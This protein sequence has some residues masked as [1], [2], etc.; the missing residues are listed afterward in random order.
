M[1][2]YFLG[3][4]PPLHPSSEFERKRWLSE[5]KTKQQSP[6]RSVGYI[7]MWNRR[8]VGYGIFRPFWNRLV[9]KKLHAKIGIC[10]NWWILSSWKCFHVFNDLFSD[11]LV[12]LLAIDSCLIQYQVAHLE[13][14]TRIPQSFRKSPFPT[15]SVGLWEDV[16]DFPVGVNYDDLLTY[17]LDI[18]KPPS[19]S[20][21]QLFS[22]YA[23]VIDP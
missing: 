9:A 3:R 1:K 19:Q 14:W 18:M 22:Q 16:E 2:P 13:L 15:I 5:I 23:E 20:L 10:I 7:T 21:L 11:L 17:F 4:R 6:K 12:L 8:K